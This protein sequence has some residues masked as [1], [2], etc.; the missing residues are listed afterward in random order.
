MGS[1]IAKLIYTFGKLTQIE[2]AISTVVAKSKIPSNEIR[3]MLRSLHP[4]QVER[5]PLFQYMR[6]VFREI[7]LGDL[8]CGE[9][10]EFIYHFNIKNSQVQKLFSDVKGKTCYVTSDALKMFFERDLDI[11]VEV[12]E[13]KCVNNGD[14]H[15]EFLVEMNPLGVLKYVVDEEDYEILE[16]LKKNKKIKGKERR[17]G[18]LERYKL[19]ENGKLTVLGEKYLEIRESPVIGE[20]ERPWKKLSEIS[21]VT[22]SAKSFAEAFSKSIEDE[23]EEIDESK[24]VNIVKEAEKSK[25]FAELMSK[26]VKKEVNEDE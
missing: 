3:L 17:M 9:V 12:R 26:V 2:A 1:G 19:I 21:E 10:D 7:G 15:C 25:S 6:G 13:I 22:A 23:V 8:R 16:S 5:T 4:L 18:T 20:V 11:P 14:E 24:I